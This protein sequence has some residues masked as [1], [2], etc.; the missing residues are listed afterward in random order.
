MWHY[1]Y[2]PQTGR[3]VSEVESDTAPVVNGLSVVSRASRAADTEMWDEASRT[4][5]PRPAKVLVDR[6]T[7][8]N[9]DPALSAVW[10][11]LTAAQA[12]ALRNRL[13][14]LLGYRR[15]RGSGEPVNLG[16]RP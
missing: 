14:A 13:I 8:L 10:T 15:F 9:N 1:L 5:T 12:T 16:D 7:D 11:R 6:I 2:N 4:F 3:L